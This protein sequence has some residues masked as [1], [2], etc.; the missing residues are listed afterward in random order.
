M[1]CCLV[2]WPSSLEPSTPL[3]AL[4]A[5]L[6]GASL[7]GPTKVGE[8]VGWKVSNPAARPADKAGKA[9]LVW[10]HELHYPGAS[11]IA[12]HFSRFQL[13]KGAALT[14]RSPDG[15]RSWTFSGTGKGKLGVTEDAS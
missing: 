6:F 3:R 13:P 5:D 11:Y 15:R 10:S 7:Q 2:R 12:P 1:R 4:E 9:A 8:E 14:V